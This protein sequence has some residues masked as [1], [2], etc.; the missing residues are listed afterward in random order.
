MDNQVQQ[1]I[2]DEMK[3]TRSDIKDLHLKIDKNYK[4]LTTKHHDL[5]KKVLT[6]KLKMGTFFSLLSIFW[7]SVVTYFSKKF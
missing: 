1:L 2:L 5:D 3:G 4:E 7:G 6:N